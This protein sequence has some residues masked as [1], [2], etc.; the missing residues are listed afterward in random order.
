MMATG[1]G[2]PN[3]IDDKRARVVPFVDGMLRDIAAE[4][5]WDL[6]ALMAEWLARFL[7]ENHCG[8]YVLDALEKL[9]LSKLP[10][11]D[12]A[13]PAV[14]EIRG[15]ELHIASELYAHGGHSRLL[16]ILV[17]HGAGR[18]EVLITRPAAR[19]SLRPL[20]NL[21]DDRLHIVQSHDPLQQFREIA[22][23]AAKFSHVIL[24]VHPDDVIC[25]TALRWLAIAPHRPKVHLFNHS[26]HTFSVGVDLAD[27]VLEI[28][29]FGWALRTARAS[30]DK[31]SFVGIPIRRPA[32]PT[33][34]AVE[35]R[36]PATLFSAGS[37]YKFRPQRGASF[38]ALMA[39]LLHRLPD[40]TLTVVG[41]R[42]T[43]AWW[44][45]L[46]LRLRSRVR[47]QQRLPHAEYLKQLHRCAIYLDSYPVTGGTAFTE[48]LIQGC[49]VASLKGASFGY[50]I[51]DGLRT[52]STE[53]LFEQISLLL[54]R[55]ALTL[56]RQQVMRERALA[57]H[58]P[59]ATRQRMES[60]LRDGIILPPPAEFAQDAPHLSFE[61]QWSRRRRVVSPGFRNDRQARLFP[62]FAAR[63][64]KAFGL[65][66]SAP[67]AL[68]AKAALAAAT[69]R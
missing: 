66:H 20:L 12:M 56:E 62:R 68:L 37:A 50:G 55:D 47:L 57:F 2:E 49:S 38:P 11:K 13:P 32:A 7:V 61:E 28:S 9:L 5:N 54:S 58:A 41:P 10:H 53:E 19:D 17:A 60:V 26:D 29:T 30:L 40:A 64:L 65:R 31:S 14:P 25:T 6:A 27:A 45:P 15:Q 16:A 35:E 3:P 69:R 39:E 18:P 1:D 4:S 46:R 34:P 36:L 8:V 33:S 48:A 63:M 67:V 22:C 59:D 52:A 44:W 23:I 43:D 21:P 24:H 42:A 51:A